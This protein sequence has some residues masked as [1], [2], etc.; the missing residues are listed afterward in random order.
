MSKA[1]LYVIG[2]CSVAIFPNFVQAD[3]KQDYVEYSKILCV[4]RLGVCRN[5]LATGYFDVVINATDDDLN[6]ICDGKPRDTRA[7]QCMML[8][9]MQLKGWMDER[10]VFQPSGYIEYMESLPHKA[11]AKYWQTVEAVAE[12][13]KFYKEIDGCQNAYVTVKCLAD[14]G[15]KYG[16]DGF[17]LHYLTYVVTVYV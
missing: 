7:S 6:A 14:E 10:G 4:E 11:D 8:C 12:S 5:Q 1:F 17:G 13:C 9:E 3:F 16:Y 2:A 15:H